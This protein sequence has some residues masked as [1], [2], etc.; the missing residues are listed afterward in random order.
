MNKSFK[1]VFSKARSALMVVNEAT[2]SIQAKG[3]KTVIAAAAAAMI[4][5]G[6]MAAQSTEKTIVI[7]T[8]TTVAGGTW[9]AVTGAKQESV[10]IKAGTVKLEGYNDAYDV[11][12]LG[13][14]VVIDGSKNT[15]TW[16]KAG[17]VGYNAVKGAYGDEPTDSKTTLVK[18]A[19]VTITDSANFGVGAH[20]KEGYKDA[21]FVF[22]GAQVTLAGSTN[23]K[24][25]VIFAA[26]SSNEEGN[27]VTLAL[28]NGTTL[29]VAKDKFGVLNTRKL[30]VD[31]AAI[32]VNGS[33]SVG[34]IAQGADIATLFAGNADKT[35]TATF[36]NSTVN[37]GASGMFYMDDATLEDTAVT[38]AGTLGLADLTVKNS[39]L[40]NAAKATLDPDTLTMKS[41]KLVNAGTFGTTADTK[42]VTI[43][44]TDVLNGAAVVEN[45]GKFNA[46][47]VVVDG[48]GAFTNTAAGELIAGSVEIN[49]GGK[50]TTA[51]S[52]TTKGADGKE[53]K[54][55]NYQ[56]AQTTVN[57]GGELAVTALNSEKFDGIVIYGNTTS[58]AKLTL[59]GGQVTYQGKVYQGNLKLGS[60]D[61]VGQLTLGNGDYKLDTLSVWHGTITE[62]GSPVKS[63]ATIGKNA[64]LTV[65]A[66]DLT[67]GVLVNDGTLTVTGTATAQAGATVTNTG[68]INVG[69]ASL[70][71]KVEGAN[72][73][74]N[75]TEFGKAAGTAGGTIVDTTRTTA[76]KIG[77]LNAIKKALGITDSVKTTLLFA[78]SSLVAN[79]GK[80]LTFSAVDGT[81]SLN[82]VATSD[83]AAVTFSKDSMLGALAFD[84]TKVTT[85]VTITGPGSGAV[86]LAGDASGNVFTGVASGKAVNVSGNVKLGAGIDGVTDAKA[87]NVANKL[88]VGQAAK[89]GIDTS[90]TAKDITN[91]GAITVTGSLAAASLAGGT[92]T[93][94]GGDLYV[95]GTA[96]KAE[97]R[98]RTFALRAAAPSAEETPKYETAFAVE[99]KVGTQGTTPNFVVFGTTD[100]AVKAKAL[101]A[102]ESAEVSGS[103]AVLYVDKHLSLASGA[104]ALGAQ[105]P[106]SNGTLTSD[107][108]TAVV[109]DTQAIAAHNYAPTEGLFT[110]VT[111][112]NGTLSGNVV[113]TNLTNKAFTK[114]ADGS[115]S[116]LLG[117]NVTV[118]ADKVA[119]DAGFYI[120]RFDAASKSLVVAADETELQN[121]KDAGVYIAGAVAQDV[122]TMTNSGNQLVRDVIYGNAAHDAFRAAQDAKI[123]ALAENG[124]ALVTEAGI[125]NAYFNTQK[126][127]FDTTQLGDATLKAQLEALNAQ[128]DAIEN[129][130]GAYEVASLNAAA[131]MAVAGGAFTTALDINDQVTATLNR[132]TSL[133]NLNV[134]R[135][136]VGITP[137]VDVF[138]TTNEAKRLYGSNAGYEADIYG[139]VL[140][141]DYTASCGSVIGLALNVGTADGNSV[142]DGV[143]VDNDTDF[144]GV[145]LYA[146]RQFGDFN[147]QADLGYTQTSNDLKTNGAYGAYSE[148]LDADVFTFGVGT[149][150]LAS[151][152]MVNV[153]PHAG[154]RLT[155]IDMDASKFGA[156]YDKMTVYQLPLGVT[157][158][159]NFEAAGFKVAPMVDVSVVPT[160]GDKD[161]V[162]SFIGQDVTTRVVDTNPVQAKLGVTAQSGAW[163]FGINYGLTAG[164]DDR[165]NNSLNANVRYTF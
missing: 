152:G 94:T 15:G 163:T 131:N 153:V 140:G 44:N 92:V 43:G 111:A 161:A 142:G 16:D 90:V 70:I 63:T 67:K 86:V 151:A 156:D 141:F 42:M 87:I 162:A 150:F 137:W 97:T 117:D 158:S 80:N 126:N 64:T 160:F 62:N 57:E 6:A 1:V 73:S 108:N 164:G 91:S 74:F 135:A 107:I 119:T 114:N 60:K 65:N 125:D 51:I 59:N 113:L 99:T 132:R 81:K 39:T 14:S 116:M 25:S 56:V 165:M 2:S 130:A 68:T 49:K 3:T 32:N 21:K 55:Q 155:T 12:V 29:S 83:N 5:G 112:N 136:E 134:S 10:T 45:S 27:A 139:A 149:E 146:A 118:G 98:A 23:A 109:I 129:A 31:N 11:Q 24:A 20:A 40:T 47:A 18:G 46:K 93:L 154:I 69:V 82:T 58:A 35:S 127:R 33:L 37:V 121:L 41:G 19:T 77:E 22:D 147:V 95:A 8:D 124:K 106:T 76:M 61:A 54:V 120:A 105:A 89:L 50:L 148:S 110:G 104:V 138:G 36:T 115:F 157:F 75:A 53:T 4:A 102:L 85:D 30:V 72:S 145:S 101:K 26:S 133:A 66:L 7:D 28:T 159:G 34:A 122:R 128:M 143:K 96:P 100:T 13:G 103:T 17:L 38:N 144:Y 52:T 79:D 48:D 9:S 88:V 78:N 123:D 84:S 71:S